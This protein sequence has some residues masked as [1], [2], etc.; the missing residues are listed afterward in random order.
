MSKEPRDIDAIFAEG[1]EIDRALEKAER[2]AILKHKR[3]GLPIP[4]WVD[5]KVQWV[6]PNLLS[7]RASR[8][9]RRSK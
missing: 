3:A 8:K 4:M 6:D 7:S 1:T 9:V 5:G 2:R